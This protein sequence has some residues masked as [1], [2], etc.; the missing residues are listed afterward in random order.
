MAEADYC[1]ATGHIWAP[2]IPQFTPIAVGIPPWAP[3]SCAG[4]NLEVTYEALEVAGCGK[5]KS[6]RIWHAGRAEEALLPGA[7]G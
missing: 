5:N 2:E 1:T 6:C 3:S 7:H 4:G